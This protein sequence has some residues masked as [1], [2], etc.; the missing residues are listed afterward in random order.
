MS[1]IVLRKEEKAEH[2]YLKHYIAQITHDLVDCPSQLI[3]ASWPH[4]VKTPHN[5]T[6]KNQF[7]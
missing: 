1:Q 5:W 3:T 7:L 6:R 2:T 4:K